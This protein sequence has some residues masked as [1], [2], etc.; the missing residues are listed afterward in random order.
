VPA[1]WVDRYKQEAAKNWELFY[2]RNRDRFF[3][4]RHY[5]QAEWSEL[6]PVSAPERDA[7][8]GGGELGGGAGASALGAREDDGAAAAA[9]A[10]LARLAGGGAERLVL[11]EAGCGV[12]N[13]LFP[14]LRAHPALFVYAFDFSDTAVEIVKA[15]PL[16]LA[17]RVTAAVGDL[18]VGTLP[19]ELAGCAADVCT[20]MFVL[21]AIAP[22]KFGSA[23]QATAS[24]LREGGVVLF[25]DYGIG[26]GAQTRLEGS[27]APKR[28]DASAAWMV[29]QDGTL[30]YYFST[31]ELIEL[32]GRAGFDVLQCEYS[33]RTT[34]NRAK[35]LTLARRYITARFRKRSAASCGS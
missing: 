20:L 24:G 7:G 29:R 25:R 16:A 1:Y 10:E 4:D 19:S 14:L 34:T 15:N 26:D 33:H 23:L 12:G 5:L 13:T 31:E 32:F 27:R 8:G 2:R 18:T 21:S 22:D 3:K 17:G 35:G 9:G 30:T 28:L 6:V 11:L